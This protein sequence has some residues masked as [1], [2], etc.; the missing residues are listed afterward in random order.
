MNKPI[1]V[2][3]MVEDRLSLVPATRNSDVLLRQEIIRRFYPGLIVLVDGDEA[4]KFKAEYTVPS[5]ET[6]K[7]WRAKFQNTWHLYVP[8]E[9]AVAKAR[10]FLRDEWTNALGYLPKGEESRQAVAQE[11][12]ID[13]DM[14][15]AIAKDPEPV[16]QAAFPIDFGRRSYD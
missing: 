12:E 13:K 1:Q 14:E 10:G 9:W 3:D 16:G 8:T 11:A 4:I 7:R 5:G 6:V 15:V 2:K